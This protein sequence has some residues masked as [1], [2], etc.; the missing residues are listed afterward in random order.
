MVVI[1]HKFTGKE[2]DAESGLDYFGARH[3]A[4]SMGRWMVP[5]KP[6]DDQ[7]PSDPQSWN[8][9]SYVRNNPLRF[10][11]PNGGACVQGS[12][13]S[14]H[15][16]NSGGESCAQVDVN[17][18]TTG[19]SVTVSATTDDVSYQ[20]ANNVA[21]LTST[22]S[23]SEVGVNGMLWAGSARAAWLIAAFS[24]CALMSSAQQNPEAPG[25]SG[26]ALLVQP[27]P[28]LPL[29]FE[30]IEKRFPEVQGEASAAEIIKSKVYRDSVGRIRQESDYG[31][32]LDAAGSHIVT[33]TDAVARSAVVLLS[34]SKIA[35]RTQFPIGSSVGVT[36][37]G[38]A[39]PAG[40]W[41]TKTE[42][43]GPRI[44][45]GVEF[46]GTRITQT[47]EGAA[48]ILPTNT[49]ETW[50]SSELKLTGSVDASGPYGTHSARIENLRR[51]EPDPTLFEVPPDYKVVDL[52][53]PSP[54]Q[55]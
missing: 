46:E 9:Y 38:E 24:L 25:R 8:L 43:L 42:Q 1:H 21:N 45:D 32:A 16:D 36:G 19:P 37:F 26:A 34:G 13:G 12:D 20:L 23:L 52:K 54:E 49:I 55:R 35:Y 41:K 48:N 50:Y 31:A 51:G 11:D 53:V 47:M 14:Y 40:N 4:S 39:L 18:A 5:D 33:I 17:N 2:R 7:A 28:G 44:I 29:S 15:D 30:Q 10:T 27:V 22:S 3:Y 6:F